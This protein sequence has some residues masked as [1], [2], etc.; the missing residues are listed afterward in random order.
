MF[1]VFRKRTCISLDNLLRQIIYTDYFSYQTFFIA[2]VNGKGK[3][4]SKPARACDQCYETVFPLLRE[5]EYQDDEERPAAPTLTL[6]RLPRLL[7]APQHATARP[8]SLL[9]AIDSP[10]RRPSEVSFSA[11]PSAYTDPM[12]DSTYSLNAPSDREPGQGHGVVRLKSSLRPRSYH[13]ILEDFH[14][15]PPVSPSAVDMTSL[16]DSQTESEFETT[17]EPP[18]PSPRENTARRRKRFSL[19]AVALQ[20]TAVTAHAGGPNAGG[21]KRFSLVLGTRRTATPT[22]DREDRGRP[23]EDSAASR[24]SELLGR[25]R[26]AEV[27]I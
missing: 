14:T 11:S 6:A 16:M 22:S 4:S 13:Q 10:S 23:R 24:L 17:V 5:P 26:Q 3:E 12:N 8:A 7:D 20:T 15:P 9:M 2:D 18:S 21:G 1:G 25:K 19:P 27:N